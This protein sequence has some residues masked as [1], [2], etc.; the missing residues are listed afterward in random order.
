VHA[1][2]LSPGNALQCNAVDITLSVAHVS[3]LG[4][5]A[6]HAVVLLDGLNSTTVASKN[7]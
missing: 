1:P 7:A 6:D 4:L 2:L 3:Y 5:L